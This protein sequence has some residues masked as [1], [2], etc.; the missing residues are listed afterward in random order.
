MDTATG[1]AFPSSWRSKTISGATGLCSVVCSSPTASGSMAG[2]GT[3]TGSLRTG[4]RASASG[5]TWTMES[6][7]SVMTS[8]TPEITIGG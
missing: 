6:P 2:A 4:S 7:R 3:G 8:S 1:V 5:I